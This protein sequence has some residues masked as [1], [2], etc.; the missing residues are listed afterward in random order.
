MNSYFRHVDAVVLVY[1][2]TNMSSF[3]ALDKWLKEC[4]DNNVEHVQ[5]ILVGNKCD[6]DNKVVSIDQA[7]RFADQHNM[8]VS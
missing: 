5:K 4:A 8:A 6:A 3:I 7:M 2:V 1:D